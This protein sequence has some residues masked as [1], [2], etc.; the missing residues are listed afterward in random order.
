MAGFLLVLAGVI[1]GGM[2][3]YDSY[4]TTKLEEECNTAKLRGDWATLEVKAQQWA[5]WEPDNYKPWLLLALAAQEVG[6][7]EQFVKYLQLLPENTPKEKLLPALQEMSDLLNQANRMSEASKIFKRMVSLAPESW[8]AHRR[9]NFYY[10]MTRQRN[11]LLAES[12]RA[13][14]NEGAAIPETFTYLIAA[15]WLTFNNGYFVN[16]AWAKSSPPEELEIYDV[17]GAIHLISAGVGESM[18]EPDPDLKRLLDNKRGLIDR[19]RKKY[20]DNIELL[21]LELKSYILQA[22]AEKVAELL[23]GLQV[24]VD[25]DSR[26]WRFKGWFHSYLEEWA[27]AEEAYRTCLELHPYDWQCRHELAV[28]LR[29]LQKNEEMEPM[30]KLADEGRQIMRDVLQSENSA[31]LGDSIHLKIAGYIRDCGNAVAADQLEK[32]ITEGR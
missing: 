25:N 22:N 29:A 15:D 5:Q 10:V 30:Q 7:K 20:P 24:N 9:L 21:C 12:K 16:Q 28:V 4:Q 32:L 26:F 3:V 23:S 27:E 2:W 13:I 11:N 8:E 31:T 18:E 19:L 17:G 6:A 14:A 1:Y